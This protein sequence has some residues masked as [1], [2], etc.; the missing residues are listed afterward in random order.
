MRSEKISLALG[1]VDLAGHAP[2]DDDDCGSACDPREADGSRAKE[3]QNATATT[4]ATTHAATS[5]S[6]IVPSDQ[7]SSRFANAAIERPCAS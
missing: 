3:L 7:P 2:G 6:S 1:C 5:T 4:S